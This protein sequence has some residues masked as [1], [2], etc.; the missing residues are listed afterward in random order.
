MF[1]GCVRDTRVS[2]AQ[3]G[4]AEAEE[5]EETIYCG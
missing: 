4:P 5:K 3:G 2:V 1:R